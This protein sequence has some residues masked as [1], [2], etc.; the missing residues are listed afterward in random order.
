MV[1]S[2]CSVSHLSEGQV[3]L[4]NGYIS[5]VGAKTRFLIGYREP[6]RDG[7]EDIRGARRLPS[8]KLANG[9]LERDREHRRVGRA[10]SEEQLPQFR[11]TP[12]LIQDDSIRI[13]IENTNTCTDSLVTA[14]DDE[15]LLITDY[16]QN[17]MIKEGESETRKF[18]TEKVMVWRSRTHHP[19]AA[20]YYTSIQFFLRSEQQVFPSSNH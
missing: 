9:R 1:S 11:N 14:F 16:L 20:N 15:T 8:L 19:I 2:P 3:S 17:D 18:Q 7:A 6:E 10:A 4:I 12:R 13:S 5:G